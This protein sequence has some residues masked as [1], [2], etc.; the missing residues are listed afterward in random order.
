MLGDYELR[1]Y[2]INFIISIGASVLGLI[3]ALLINEKKDKQLFEKYFPPPVIEFQND[4]EDNRPRVFSISS[5]QSL[6]PS[7][8][9]KGEEENKHIMKQFFDLK[10]IHEMYKTYS[11][12]RPFGIRL[13]ILLLMISMVMFLLSYS[14]PS[15][16]LYQY[17]QKLFNWDSQKYALY[18]AMSTTINL[19]TTFVFTP[20]IIRVSEPGVCVALIT[21]PLII[22]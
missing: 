22:S 5:I 7:L 15:V 16:F 11:R 19:I 21:L 3:N 8:M 17:V 2:S 1:N 13:Q 10:N 6:P 18:Y 20:I 14:G 12:E 9:H 4:D